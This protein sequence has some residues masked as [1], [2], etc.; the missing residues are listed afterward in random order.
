MLEKMRELQGK[1]IKL[2]IEISSKIDLQSSKKSRKTAFAAKIDESVASVP[3]LS[4][5]CAFS[6]DFWDSGGHPKI[7]KE[8][9][10]VTPLISLEISCPLPGGHFG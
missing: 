4:R 7:D 9:Q 2:S 1:I 5:K 8:L 6:V 3:P 10:K